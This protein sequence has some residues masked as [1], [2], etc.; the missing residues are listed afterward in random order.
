MFLPL[1]SENALSTVSSVL[2]LA[3]FALSISPYPAA[4]IA[5]TTAFSLGTF[6]LEL[7]NVWDIS[8][9]DIAP[10]SVAVNWTAPVFPLT[11]WTGAPAE[12]I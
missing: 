8:A 10:T 11:V 6:V 7:P 2:L 3:Y 1:A 4:D 9:A 12:V 5:S